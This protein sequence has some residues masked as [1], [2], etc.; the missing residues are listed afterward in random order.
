MV[1]QALVQEGDPEMGI[2]DEY[3][4]ALK[5]S[6]GDM[7]RLRVRF[8]DRM[9]VRL[10]DHDDDVNAERGS[11]LEQILNDLEASESVE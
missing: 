10:I 9:V 3:V 2:Q 7:I 4:T 5:R 11:A 1:C 6:E 8:M